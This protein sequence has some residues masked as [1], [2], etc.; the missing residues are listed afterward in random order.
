MQRRGF[1]FNTE[2]DA[3]AGASFC[4]RKAPVPLQMKAGVGDNASPTSEYS[5]DDT[6]HLNTDGH[7][8]SKEIRCFK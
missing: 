5:Q 6:V 2:T 7:Q 4:G 3:L 1:G 8:S